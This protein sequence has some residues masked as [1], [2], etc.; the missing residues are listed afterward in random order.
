MTHTKSSARRRV[1]GFFMLP[2]LALGCL[3]LSS[4]SAN[5]GTEASDQF[6]SAVGKLAGVTEVSSFGVN[7][8]PFAGSGDATITVDQA[9]DAGKVKELAHQVGSIAAGQG[10]MT[11]HKIELELGKD[12]VAIVPRRDDITDAR[13]DRLATLRASGNFSELHLGSGYLNVDQ[14]VVGVV[15]GTSLCEMEPAYDE[16]AKY[17]WP[18]GNGQRLTVAATHGPDGT[19]SF[20]DARGPVKPGPV[21]RAVFATVCKD[22]TAGIRRLAADGVELSI[23]AYSAADADQI[24]SLIRSVPGS[25]AIRVKVTER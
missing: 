20:G 23:A 11:W 25:E 1:A 16:L 24:E 8:L 9:L 10:G 3:G 14:D 5:R 13:L 15:P 21:G 7:N 22:T 2:L 19:N 6:D 12:T 17:D 4:C 18:D